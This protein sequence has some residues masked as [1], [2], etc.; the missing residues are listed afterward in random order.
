[1][2]CPHCL[3][4]SNLKPVSDTEQ[5]LVLRCSNPLC[6]YPVVPLLYGDD[7]GSHPPSPF[8]II[9]LSGHGKTVYIESLLHEIQQLGAKWTDS[10]FHFTWLDE[11][12]M[13][14]AYSRLKALRNGQLP[15][16]TKTVFMRPQVLRLSNIPCV[17]GS[18]LVI[19]DMGGE[20]F[21]DS[22]TL[23]EHG[24]YLRHTP[25]IV[26]LLSLKKGDPYDS[27]DDVNQMMTVYLQTMSRLG[28]N[29]KE[30]TLILVLTK[31]DELLNRSDL[32]E[33]AKTA[34]SYPNYSP[35]G[36][37][38]NL[39]DQ[40][41]TDLEAWLRSEMCG[42]HNLVNLVKSRFKNVRYSIVSAQ[43]APAAGDGL[44]FGMM[45]RGVLS[46]LLWLWR[47]QRDLV[48]VELNGQKLLHL[49]L[50]EAVA[51][52]SGGVVQLEEG[53]Y[54]LEKPLNLRSP[55]Q[56]LGRGNGKTV[57]E[58]QAPSYGIG[59]AIS[60]G[61][62]LIKGLSLR[63]VGPQ[64]GDIIRVMQGN[65]DLQDCFVGG[66]ITGQL[67]G[68]SVQ[69]AGLLIAKQAKSRIVSC[70][71]KGNQGNGILFMDQSSGQ[72]YDCTLEGNGDAGVYVR[73]EGVVHV[74]R[75]AARS[76][77][78]GIWIEAVGQGKIEQ[79]IA[80]QNGSAGIVASGT[81][82]S[83]LQIIGNFA[84]NNRRDGILA[85]ASTAALFLKNSCSGNARNGIALTDDSTATA[86]ENQVHRNARNGIRVSDN[87]SPLIESNTL[88]ENTESGIL[89]EGSASGEVRSN[90]IRDNQGDGIRLEGTGSPRIEENRSIGN[91]GFGIAVA[92]EQ[93]KVEVD[94]KKNS[95]DTNKRGPLMDVR[96]KKGS[97]WW[98]R[99]S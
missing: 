10:Q 85:R 47:L 27:P 35:S 17:G 59:V 98:S 66:A 20:A 23:V 69:G 83:N 76:N 55:I 78:T 21:L 86:K 16:G 14:Q 19:F 18:Q 46:P 80:E 53:T 5:G 32:P 65:L 28:G 87:A 81:T 9:G 88:E 99:P 71:F 97:G 11:V 67:E 70:S 4:D 33:S 38:W 39:L 7:Y 90:S 77:Q 91:G 96:S 82:T 52:S 68:R 95:A 56:I 49:D 42:Y 79:C 29:T 15:K 25:A 64:P 45:P 6:D 48:W 34:L 30:Q 3:Q 41:S 24:K 12:Q 13:R 74:A 58:L 57:I 54:R 51:A 84:N 94:P 75:A 43:G 72:V 62:A 73:T 1:M 60:K 50:A 92:S 93:A 40:A 31:G 61:T 36:Q 26:W 63:R 37:V 44:Q 2:L 8:C 22:A 89:F